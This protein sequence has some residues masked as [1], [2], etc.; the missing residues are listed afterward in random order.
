MFVKFQVERILGFSS[1]LKAIH[2][3]CFPIHIVLCVTICMVNAI[4]KLQRK[5]SLVER[6]KID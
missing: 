6:I 4:L 3:A 1:K 5:V 2:K